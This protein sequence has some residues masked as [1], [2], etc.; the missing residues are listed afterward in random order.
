MATSHDIYESDNPDVNKLPT[1]YRIPIDM[2]LLEYCLKP[3]EHEAKKDLAQVIKVL[4]EY[5][6]K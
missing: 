1:I 3:S 4:Q 6:D 5:L 2:I